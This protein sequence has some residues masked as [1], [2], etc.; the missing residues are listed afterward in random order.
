MIALC[1]FTDV[2][3]SIKF[4][5]SVNCGFIYNFQ[6]TLL[7]PNKE[8]GSLVNS[9][10]SKWPF[11]V[12]QP[13][14]QLQKLSPKCSKHSIIVYEKGASWLITT[15]NKKLTVLFPLPINLLNFLVKSESLV[16]LVLLRDLR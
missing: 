2:D 16:A 8:E 5:L 7:I 1:G 9:T 13:D 12:Y 3:S 15:G 11:E 4:K 10:V 14:Y 6:C